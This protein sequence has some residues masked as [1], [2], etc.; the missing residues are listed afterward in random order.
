MALMIIMLPLEDVSAQPCHC[1]RGHMAASQVSHATVND[2]DQEESHKV[3][4]VTVKCKHCTKNHCCCD[5]TGCGCVALTHVFMRFFSEF[6]IAFSAPEFSAIYFNG[7]HAQYQ[8][9]PLLRPPIA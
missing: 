9:L 6:D 5:S 3:S 4:V 8:S 7:F 2:A 1:D